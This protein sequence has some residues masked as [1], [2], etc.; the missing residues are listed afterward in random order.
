MTTEPESASLLQEFF[1]GWLQ[2]ISGVLA[3]VR[4]APLEFVLEAEA[5]GAPAPAEDDIWL[6]IAFGAP[7]TGVLAVRFPAASALQL[8][9]IFM[10]EDSTE[11]SAMDDTHREALEELFRQIA[12]RAQT[13]MEGLKGAKLELTRGSV[14]DRAAASKQWLYAKEPIFIELR[15]SAELAASLTSAGFVESTQ[16][17]AAQSE[18][19]KS[20]SASMPGGN[21]ELLM[22]VELKVTVR[23][24]QRRMTL[25]EVLDLASGAVVELDRG[26]Q[27]P[28]DLLLDN[29]VIARGEVVVV[30][31]NYGLRLIEVIRSQAA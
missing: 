11:I 4:G 14:P 9:K 20:G 13:S 12:G 1:A 18:P 30:E 10:A 8:A 27:E 7:L 3:E 21:L 6:D 19:D 29:K 25:G 15:V 31:G 28:V 23:F 24:G 16:P 2:N 22:G 17:A 26:V 5:P